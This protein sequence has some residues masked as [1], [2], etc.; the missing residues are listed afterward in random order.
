MIF[1][2]FK[3]LLCI[4]S[5]D[6]FLNFSKIKL[7]K[8][9]HDSS[10]GSMK[11]SIFLTMQTETLDELQ[12]AAKANIKSWIAKEKPAY[13]TV[14]GPWQTYVMRRPYH[15]R[16][17]TMKTMKSKGKMFFNTMGSMLPLPFLDDREKS[18]DTI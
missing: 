16:I 18:T 10:I 11:F 6:I 3:N 15:K 2:L 17:M 1:L 14:D 13:Y 12:A 9:S 8:V 4:I 5:Y 7:T